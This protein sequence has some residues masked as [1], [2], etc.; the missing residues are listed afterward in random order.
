MYLDTRCYYLCFKYVEGVNNCIENTSV[1]VWLSSTT[2]FCHLMDFVRVRLLMGAVGTY[3]DSESPHWPESRLGIA[4][5]MHIPALVVT[6]GPKASCE[7]RSFP[8]CFD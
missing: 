8:Q 3:T 7:W 1:I 5:F 6:I 4:D 2:S